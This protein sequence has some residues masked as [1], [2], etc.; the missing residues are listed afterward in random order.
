[1]S[2]PVDYYTTVEKLGKEYQFTDLSQDVE[3]IEEYIAPEYQGEYDS[4]FF[5]YDESGTE[6]EEIYGMHGI[7]P[8][9]WKE[10]CRVK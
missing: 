5:K 2:V 10:V 9:F 8:E 6:Y 7:I 1:M 3:A 4:F